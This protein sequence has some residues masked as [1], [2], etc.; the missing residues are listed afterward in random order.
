MDDLKALR[1]EMQAWGDWSHDPLITPQPPPL[2]W[3][4]MAARLS[5]F[6]E[7]HEKERAFQE[8]AKRYLDSCGAKDEQEALIAFRRAL[9]ERAKETT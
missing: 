6:I 3:W 5:S 2:N 7:Q 1:D 4:K 8:A 9:T